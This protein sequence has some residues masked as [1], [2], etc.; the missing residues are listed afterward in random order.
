MR[1]QT[2]YRP[3]PSLTHKNLIQESFEVPTL[4]QLLAACCRHPRVDGLE[5]LSARNASPSGKRTP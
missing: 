4:G 1:T 3:F 5:R 2:E